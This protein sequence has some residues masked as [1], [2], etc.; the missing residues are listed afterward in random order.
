MKSSDSRKILIN[1]IPLL[2]P[3]SG[4][5]NYTYQ[6]A[7]LLT[8]LD[9]ASDYTYYYG[10]RSNKLLSPAGEDSFA[11]RIK[12]GLGTIP[13]FNR[14]LRKVR[15]KLRT[16]S[17]ETYDLYF[18]PNFI[19]LKVSA[20]RK[21]ATVHDFSFAL[22]PDWHPADRVEHFRSHFWSNIGECDRI[23]VVS[24]FI[25]EACIGEYGLPAEKVVRIHNGYDR[26]VFR[27][28]DEEELDEVGTRY[29]LA[30]R[31]ILSVGSIEPRKNL[32]GLLRAY[33]LLPEDMRAEYR[34]LLVG[35]KGWQNARIM[36]MIDSLKGQVSYLGY[37]PFADLGRIYNL[38]S[39]F[40][41]PSFYEG[42][43]LPPLEAMACGCPTITSKES[44]LP[45]VCGDA[46]FYIDPAD[47][48]SLSHGI[49][50]VLQDTELQEQLVA[51]G[52]LR[53]QVFSW[54]DSAV[55]HLELFESLL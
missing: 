29:C 34:L 45:E 9:P 20:K 26:D 31:F 8:D 48:E 16:L 47:V 43:G 18:E 36:E 25:R 53:A 3:L 28:Y 33:M 41:Y 4:V 10:Y 38:A 23:I 17:N 21:V 5:G 42:F 19:P 50:K 55:K 52:L 12:N 32:E 14:L 22:H 30:K 49:G 39:L 27:A 44:S 24:D 15:A 51:K 54:E 13:G 11:F 1:T 37:V 7:R 40:V 2:S 46:V 35:F 6:I